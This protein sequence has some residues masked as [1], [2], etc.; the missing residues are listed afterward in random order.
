[1]PCVFLGALQVKEW[2]ALGL[3]V[4]SRGSLQR[5]PHGAPA[6]LHPDD[7]QLLFSPQAVTDS[8]AEAATTGPIGDETRA[9]GALDTEME[10]T[11]D[12]SDAEGMEQAEQQP[13]EEATALTPSSSFLQLA[14]GSDCVLTVRCGWD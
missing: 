1:M 12:R 8:G 3:R 5:G 4:V 6:L 13:V 7:L 11:G 14:S 9:G 10:G 2:P